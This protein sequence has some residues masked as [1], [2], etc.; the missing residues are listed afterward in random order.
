MDAASSPQPLAVGETNQNTNETNPNVMPKQS[1]AALIQKTKSAATSSKLELTPVHMVHGEPTVEFTVEEVNTFTIEEGLHQAV[2]LKFSYGKPDIQELRQL[3]PKQFDI[4]GYC[5]VGQLEF[6]HI[7]V[8]FDLFED[9]VQVLSRSTGYVKAKGDEFFFRTFPWTLGFN[10]REETSRAVAWISLPDLPANFFAKKSLLSIA[11]AVG[12]PLAIDKATQ[13]RTRPS[14]ARVKVLI[15]LLNKHPKRVRINIVDKNSGRIVEHYQQIVFDNLPEYCTCCKH[16]GHDENSCRRR[17]EDGKETAA[18]GDVV[19]GLGS[20]DKLAGDARDYLNA[21][22]A[23]QPRDQEAKENPI[24]E[25]LKLDKGPPKPSR[26]VP[27][28]TIFA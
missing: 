19:E 21:K 22:R 12:K 11:S 3:I 23:V 5:N 18:R 25:V 7:L 15:N 1:Y 9:Y 20:L 16:Q 2:I 26:D 10:P 8:R 6:R 28:S 4:K 17:I 27:A 24:E 14:T 13:D